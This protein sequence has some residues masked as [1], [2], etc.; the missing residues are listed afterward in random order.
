M[1]DT[2]KKTTTAANTKSVKP[3]GEKVKK[4][5]KLEDELGYQPDKMER[6][7]NDSKQVQEKAKRSSA[8]KGESRNP[9][10]EREKQE[11]SEDKLEQEPKLKDN[12]KG[13]KKPAK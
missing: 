9:Q 10:R 6:S 3:A 11:F 12:T 5:S 13:A 7:A 2:S 4:Y 8:T 1:K